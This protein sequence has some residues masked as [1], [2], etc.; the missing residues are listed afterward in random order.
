MFS[1]VALCSLR[2]GTRERK[3]ARC[4]Q[5][6]ANENHSRVPLIRFQKSRGLSSIATSRP[7][8]HRARSTSRATSREI[9]RARAAR[10]KFIYARAR[11]LASLARVATAP[12]D[13][14]VIHHHDHRSVD[15]DRRCRESIDGC[16]RAISISIARA[17]DARHA[18]VDID[19]KRFLSHRRHDR[20][21]R[22]ERRARVGLT[23]RVET[24]GCVTT[25]EA[26][27]R[28]DCFF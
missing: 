22:S 4:R 28:R 26:P 21:N 12:R 5:S 9:P 3:S 20:R 24:T 18:P 7:I 27:D 16:R 17:R 11:P 13:D 10:H 23:T 15:R 6:S 14:G 19:V 2:V 8:T 25:R 1:F